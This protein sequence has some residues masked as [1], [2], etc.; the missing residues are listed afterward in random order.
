MAGD[1]GS[2]GHTPKDFNECV[3]QEQLDDAKR[4]MHEVITKAVTEAIIGLK[5]GEILSTVTDRIDVLEACQQNN[6]DEDMVYDDQGNID[7]AVTREARLRHRLRRNTQ[8]MGGTHNHNHQQGNQ[9]C[10]PDDP[11]AKVK[12]TIPSF[13]GYYDAEGYLDC[14]M[15]VEQ[16][17]SAH[18]VPE[19]HRVR[20]ATSEFKDFAIVWWTG[21]IAEDASPTTWNDLKSAMRDR[22]VPPS[23]HR[24]LRKKLMRLEQGDKTV[25]DYYGELQK[26]LMRCAIVEGTKDAIFRFYSGLRRDIQ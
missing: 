22:F 19:Q 6:Q 1:D 18:L 7:E 5:L 2:G 3:S 13:S 8:G 10:V 11:Y 25:Q 15:T 21:L 14:E 24:D 17:F 12:F 9:N 4:E 23:Y 16:K 26:G 20:Q